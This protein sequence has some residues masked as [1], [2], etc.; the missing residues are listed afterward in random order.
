VQILIADKILIYIIINLKMEHRD[1]QTSHNI[2]QIDYDSIRKTAKEIIEGSRRIYRLIP[3]GERG[4]I[5]GGARNVEASCLLGTSERTDLSDSS[6]GQALIQ[7]QLLEEYAKH[8]GIWFNHEEIRKNWNRIDTGQSVEA[9][10]YLD[11]TGV[12]VNKV[13]HYVNSDTPMECIDDRIS[14]HN[15]LF[16]P[17]KYELL[18]FTRTIKGFAFILKQPFIKGRKTTEEDNLT[19]F[20]HKLGF[21][22]KGWYRYESSSIEIADLHEG[23]VLMGEDGNFYFID[24]IPRFMDYEIY[25][26]FVIK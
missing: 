20:M 7:E 14:L 8:E 2:K 19:G 5:E 12:Y 6:R 22:E 21:E 24:T 3:K 16:P 26:H 23:N 18:G 11:E 1:Y 4:R 9:E 17:T 15:A 10:V 25:Y 13:F